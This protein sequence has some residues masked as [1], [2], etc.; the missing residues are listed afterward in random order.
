MGTANNQVLTKRDIFS[1]KAK[2]LYL[3]LLKQSKPWKFDPTDINFY[4]YNS[5]QNDKKKD[6]DWDDVTTTRSIVFCHRS[7]RY[8]EHLSNYC[9]GSIRAGNKLFLQD[10]HQY[11]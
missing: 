5:S 6:H 2:E 9:P 8:S 4:A 1:L 7:H 11:Y 10:L 3:E